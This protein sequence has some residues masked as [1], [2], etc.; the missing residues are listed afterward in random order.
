MR[1]LRPAPKRGF[2]LIELL[3]V[4]AIIAI[5]AAILFPVFSR[6]RERARST[7]CLSNM[8]QIAQAVMMYSQDY[9]GRYPL[10]H[11]VT[12]SHADDGGYWWVQLQKYTKEDGVFI[13]PSWHA[14]DDPE[15]L[16]FWEKPQDRSQPFSRGGI[17][18][19]YA[20]NLTMNGAPEGKLSGD[21][22]DGGGYSPSSVIAVAEGFNGTH[23]WKPEQVG[24]VDSPELRLRYFHNDG[25]NVA[26]ADGHARWKRSSDMKRSD[27]APWDS[28]WRP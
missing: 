15:G 8:R 11:D 4:I 12:A 16:L 10:C 25:A 14:T 24:P 28:N 7:A 22:P 20:W 5:L 6:A 27:W 1:I 13:C 23:I 21:R 26:Y 9:K 2:T 3:V 17:R 18:G 19:T